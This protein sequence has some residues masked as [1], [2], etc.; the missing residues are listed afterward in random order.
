MLRI[1]RAFD[2]RCL[3]EVEGRLDVLS[4]MLCKIEVA[5]EEYGA[6]RMSD[7]VMFSSRVQWIKCLG[8]RLLH[9]ALLGSKN[10]CR[11]TTRS[12]DP[13]F[14]YASPLFLDAISMILDPMKVDRH[15]AR[16]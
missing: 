10:S 8:Q 12:I 5:A 15:H 14:S 2:P 6:V 9:V 4:L 1:V 13:V 11:L 16:C 7:L 3:D